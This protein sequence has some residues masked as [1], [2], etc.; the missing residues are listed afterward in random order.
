[1]TPADPRRTLTRLRELAEKAKG[2]NWDIVFSRVT[3]L[4]TYTQAEY[5]AAVDPQTVL[6]LLDQL[7]RAT[8]ALEFAGWSHC[9]D[10]GMWWKVDG[11]NATIEVHARTCP[12]AQTDQQAVTVRLEKR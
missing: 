11:E 4:L 1:M 6:S 2:Y 9:P 3:K 8:D 7:Q 10:C 5:I 12:R